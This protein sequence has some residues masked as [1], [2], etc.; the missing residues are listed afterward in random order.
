MTLAAEKMSDNTITSNI[1]VIDDQ[2]TSLD[3]LSET[4]KSIEPNISISAFQSGAEAL[5]AAKINSPD[6]VI[7]DYK[8]PNMNGIEF[9]KNLHKIPDCHDTPV[10]MITIMKEKSI[11]YEA[12]DNG[13]T[14]FLSKPFDTKEYQS[15]CKNLLSIGK[16]QANLKQQHKLLTQKVSA[17]TEE[18]LIREKETLERLTKACAYKDCVTG[19]HLLRMGNISYLLALE[20]GLTQSEAEFLKTSAPLHD[21]GKVAIPDNI[22][23]K[24]GTLTT[25]EFEVM[26][27]H[28]TI[29]YEILKESPSP[30]LQM[31]AKIALNHHEKFD[32]SGYPNGIS[33]D[34]IPIEARIATVADI[35]DSLTNDRPYKKAWPLD[36]TLIYISAIGGKHL[37]PE[38]VKALLS[39]IK[40]I[41]AMNIK[42]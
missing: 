21:I 34:E 35:F 12:L 24:K 37:D 18:V 25:S 17:T 33:G 26:K 32:G 11:L 7:T 3:I 5:A 15:K 10:M 14:D 28:T 38:C 4:I 31:G 36:E 42:S 19:E 2:S 30:Y 23:M 6:L 39:Q 9:T 40:N 29:G 8:M 22:L 13:V 20:L 27:T 16:R 41:S 1:M